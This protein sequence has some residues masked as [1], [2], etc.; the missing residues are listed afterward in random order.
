MAT[1]VLRVH[2]GDSSSANETRSFW[3]SL[4]HFFNGSVKCSS[5]NADDKTAEDP[6]LRELDAVLALLQLSRRV[7]YL[8]TLL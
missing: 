8:T 7:V 5:N 1:Y 4:V 3:Q 2:G 6:V